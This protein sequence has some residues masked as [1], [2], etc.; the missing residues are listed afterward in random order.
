MT[1]ADLQSISLYGDLEDVFER[2][3][4]GRNYN[5]NALPEEEVANFLVEKLAPVLTE[6]AD[7]I[8]RMIIRDSLARDLA[9]S[10]S[11]LAGSNITAF[12]RQMLSAS[13]SGS[14]EPRP[15]A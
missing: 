9:A 2:A 1:A 5:L 12:R 7:V 11:A 15:V 10:V 14:D 4:A 6:L 13:L 3:K 8:E